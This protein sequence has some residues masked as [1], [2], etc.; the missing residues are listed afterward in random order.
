MKSMDMA[1][2]DLVEKG[3]ISGHE[4]YLQANNKHKFEKVK[5]I[6]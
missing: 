5:D 2:M 1:L 6:E 4:A 3:R